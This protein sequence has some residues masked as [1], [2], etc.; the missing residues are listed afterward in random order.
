M[1]EQNI[2][3]IKNIIIWKEQTQFDDLGY[4]ITLSLGIVVNCI[5]LKKPEDIRSFIYYRDSVT[6][7]I[8]DLLR[9]VGWLIWDEFTDCMAEVVSHGAFIE[10]FINIIIV[11]TNIRNLNKKNNKYLTSGLSHCITQRQ[12]WLFFS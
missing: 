10:R 4:I 5:P 2:K 7:L 1:N 8:D 9:C 12:Y 3:D 6:V 11:H